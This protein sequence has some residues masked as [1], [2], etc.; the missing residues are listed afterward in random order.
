MTIDPKKLGMA[1]KLGMAYGQGLKFR[2][3]MA[4]DDKWITVKPNGENAKGRPV[5]LGENGEIKAG[6]GGKFNGQRI[7]EAR[8]SFTGPRITQ[9]QRNLKSGNKKYA[10]LSDEEV[11]KRLQE[12]L[13]DIN[14]SDKWRE[15]FGQL[16]TEALYRQNQKNEKLKKAF[17]ERDK[18]KPKVDPEL[19]KAKREKEAEEWDRLRRRERAVTS[20]AWEREKARKQKRFDAEFSK[21]RGYPLTHLVPNL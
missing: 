20:L 4:Q 11:E 19:A 12:H 9:A 5:L 8:K 10:N 7:S 14:Q 2:A 6:M 13:Q 16:R 3:G 21:K 15:E 18:N 1:F 17:K